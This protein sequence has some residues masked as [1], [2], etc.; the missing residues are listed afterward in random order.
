MSNLLHGI[1]VKANIES[2]TGKYLYSDFATGKG[3]KDSAL[4]IAAKIPLVGVVAGVVRIALAIIHTVGHLFAALVTFKEDHLW[5]AAK[6]A[7]ELLRGL[8]ETIPIIGRIFANCFNYDDKDYDCRSWW[9]IKIYNPEKPDG[10]DL[11]MNNWSDFP[12]I[13][14]RK[15][16]SFDDDGANSW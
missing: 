8:I 2:F 5:H 11:W 9:M 10:L 16:D 3:E 15:R 4:N 1:V 6:G 13:T 12:Q 7:C 14:A